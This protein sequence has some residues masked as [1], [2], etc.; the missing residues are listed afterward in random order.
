MGTAP[1]VV[2][3]AL[4]RSAKGERPGIDVPISAGNVERFAPP[5]EAVAA[6]TDHF[7]RAGFDILGRP[8]IT[9]LGT[10]PAT[11]AVLF[12]KATPPTDGPPMG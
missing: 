5:P 6:V 4:L 2:A 11:I 1:M 3:R 7:R 12:Q 10:P 8:G 9:P